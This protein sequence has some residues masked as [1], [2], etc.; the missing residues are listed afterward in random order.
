MFYNVIH[1]KIVTLLTTSAWRLKLRLFESPLPLQESFEVVDPL[2]V[3][4][5]MRLLFKLPYVANLRPIKPPLFGENFT[6]R[7][8]MYKRKTEC[9]VRNVVWSRWERMAGGQ[10]RNTTSPVNKIQY[11]RV[12]NDE[13]RTN[14]QVSLIDSELAKDFLPL[15][16]RRHLDQ[17]HNLSEWKTFITQIGRENT[18]WEKRKDNC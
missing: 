7:L 11:N 4:L 12:R 16:R 10:T 13:E 15:V 14:W 8:C 1:V 3:T 6:Q 9:I 2:W 18:I 5:P 17:L